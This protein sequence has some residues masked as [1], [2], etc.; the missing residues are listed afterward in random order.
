MKL[1]NLQF[2]GK[3]VATM[4]AAAVIGFC[5]SGQALAS[6]NLL[7]NGDF[8]SNGTGEI[9]NAN[10]PGWNADPG[11]RTL[12][13]SVST[14][15][16]DQYA[17]LNHDGENFGITQKFDVVKNTQYELSYDFG[18]SKKS[19][20]DENEL[21]VALGPNKGPTFEAEDT[22]AG[23]NK[24]Q[25]WQTF[26]Y[27]FTAETNGAFHILFASLGATDNPSA[28][29]FIDNVSIKAVPEASTLTLF[30]LLFT[31]GLLMLRRRSR[32][33]L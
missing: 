1:T 27:T 25:L 6:P 4:L 28:T 8:E 32:P 12:I 10:L 14:P 19:T 31:G 24:G 9:S 5:V 15:G 26:T 18:V 17:V 16:I 20:T 13:D 33:A 2:T 3:A 11:N 21:L 22:M 29:C 30:A 23:P 7:T